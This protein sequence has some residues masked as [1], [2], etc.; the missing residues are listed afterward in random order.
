MKLIKAIKKT[1]LI[2]SATYITIGVLMIINKQASD[3]Q[4][5]EVLAYGLAI[6][7]LL[8]M[9]RYFMLNV[10]ERIKRNDFI[11]GALLISIAAMI[12]L[13]KNDISYQ[14]GKILAIAMIISGFHKI[15]DLFDIKASG[16][17][18]TGI[19][20]FGF[21][22]CVALG[23]LVLFDV[24]KNADFLYILIGVGMCICG[25]SDIVSNFYTAYAV[26]NYETTWAEKSKVRPVPSD[27][28][29]ENMPNDDEQ[30]L[31]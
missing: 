8:S 28:E 26:A 17:N 16:K 12:Y 30:K 13:S 6:A 20:L 29:E 1:M 19:C 27:I 31:E 21:L 2:I 25:I 10:R 4:V 5:F 14:V 9:I 11:I 18:A 3:K 7:G 24:V 15:Q 23:A 22:I